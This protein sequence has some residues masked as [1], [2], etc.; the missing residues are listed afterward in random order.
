MLGRD[1]KSQLSSLSRR[2]CLSLHLQF[3]N[4]S[5]VATHYF[6]M[7]LLHCVLRHRSYYIGFKQTNI[8]TVA[9]CTIHAKI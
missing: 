7:R 5:R 3:L 8:I 2:S 9:V 6:S 4:Y 1:K